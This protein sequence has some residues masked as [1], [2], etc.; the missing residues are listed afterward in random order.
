MEIKNIENK[1]KKVNESRSKKLFGLARY[2]INCNCITLS[3][4]VTT[5]TVHSFYTITVI[6]QKVL[7]AVS[8]DYCT[9]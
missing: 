6:H 5:Y 2:V 8:H 9:L 3:T 1:P 7:I 4:Y